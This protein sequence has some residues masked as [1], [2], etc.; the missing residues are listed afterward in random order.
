[1]PSARHS[2][3]VPSVERVTLHRVTRDLGFAVVRIAGM[4]L[5]GLRVE[6]RDSR[7]TL[8]PPETVDG[9]ERRWPVY[10]LQP[11]LHEVVEAAVAVQW[12]RS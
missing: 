5:M 1:M 3:P 2:P 4:N 6:E 7:L 11:G 10:A 8:T 12:G 9:Q